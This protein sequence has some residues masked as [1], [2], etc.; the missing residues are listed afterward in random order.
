MIAFEIASSVILLTDASVRYVSRSPQIVGAL[1]ADR[2][3]CG[4]L[5]PR[6]E[7]LGFVT[8]RGDVEAADK[9]LYGITYILAPLVVENTANRRF[10][11]SETFDAKRVYL[12]LSGN[13]GCT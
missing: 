13:T 5:F 10:V 7:T 8:D 11:L 4:G 6:G 1:D 3:V 12:S 2:R 9:R